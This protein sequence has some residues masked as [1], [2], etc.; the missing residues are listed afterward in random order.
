MISPSNRNIIS[1]RLSQKQVKFIQSYKNQ[2]KIRIISTW[3][4]A[5]SAAGLAEIQLYLNYEK[6]T[7]LA[8]DLS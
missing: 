7:V 5:L 3:R 4:C 8:L 6:I 2:L 1:E